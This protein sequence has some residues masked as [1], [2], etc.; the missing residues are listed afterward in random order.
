[1]AT[2]AELAAAWREY[3][4][5]YAA[6]QAA[7]DRTEPLPAVQAAWR[8]LQAVGTPDINRTARRPQD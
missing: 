6:D 3:N 7:G 5:A 2:Q 8:K 4:A 1:M